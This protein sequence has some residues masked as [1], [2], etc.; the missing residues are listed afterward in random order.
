MWGESLQNGKTK[1]KL[2]G[3]KHEDAACPL[4]AYFREGQHFAGL[5]WETILRFLLI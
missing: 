4:T 1:S 2:E 5:N 3:R